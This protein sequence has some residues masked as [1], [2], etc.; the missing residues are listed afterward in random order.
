MCVCVCECVC[1]C[2]CVFLYVLC[3]CVY[4]CVCMCV[5]VFVC[6][7]VFVCFY[8]LVCAWSYK[9]PLFV[10]PFQ[11]LPMGVGF[12]NKNIAFGHYHP[13]LHVHVY[14]FFKTEL[15]FQPHIYI[16]S[17]IFPNHCGI[18]LYSAHTLIHWNISCNEIA[19]VCFPV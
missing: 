19:L 16:C 15:L 13:D 8:R 11:L 1:V 17:S 4:V 2:M 14:I 7:F 12:R 5:C 6:M 3:V 10:F 9:S 18:A